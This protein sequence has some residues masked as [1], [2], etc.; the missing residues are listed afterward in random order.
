[1]SGNECYI[2]TYK[3]GWNGIMAWTSNGVDTCGTLNDFVKGANEVAK[4]MG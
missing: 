3:S 1:M 2:N 4:L